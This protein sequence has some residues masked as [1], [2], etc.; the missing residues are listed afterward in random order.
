MTD[1]R[2]PERRTD[3]GLYAATC[4]AVVAAL[5]MAWL[6]AANDLVATGLRIGELE[7]RRQAALE[8]RSLWL[9][10]YAQASQPEVLADRARQLGFGPPGQVVYL[11]SDV[12]PS[13]RPEMAWARPN[14]PL[15]LLAPLPGAAGVST[16]VAAAP[17]ARPVVALV[18]DA[19]R[20]PRG[21]AAGP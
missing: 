10:R 13:S 17:S 20:Q 1:T 14:S 9:D 18:S 16:A 5:A 7:G 8:E 19:D 4:L 11:P 3:L 12:S 21:N 2:Q 15:V 6:R